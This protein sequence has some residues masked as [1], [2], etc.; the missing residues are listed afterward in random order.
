MHSSN[1]LTRLTW[2]VDHDSTY[3]ICHTKTSQTTSGDP[4]PVSCDHASRCDH[5]VHGRGFGSDQRSDGDHCNRRRS[6]SD[7]LCHVYLCNHLTMRSLRVNKVESD[8][9]Y[10][11]PIQITDIKATLRKTMQQKFQKQNNMPTEL[12]TT[13]KFKFVDNTFCKFKLLLIYAPIFYKSDSRKISA[14][15]LPKYVNCVVR[16]CKR[17]THSNTMVIA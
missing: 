5:D 1:N 4:D 7:D 6:C 13:K 12:A 17:I 14:D 9:K 11:N 15:V 8:Q 10:S 2:A 16:I 3:D